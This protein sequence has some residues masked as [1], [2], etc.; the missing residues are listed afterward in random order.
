M[1]P[2]V[3]GELDHAHAAIVILDSAQQLERVIL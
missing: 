1:L 3:A 2:I